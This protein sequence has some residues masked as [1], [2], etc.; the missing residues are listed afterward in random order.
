[1][2]GPRWTELVTSCWKLLIIDALLSVVSFRGL[3]GQE[4]IIQLAQIIL[5]TLSSI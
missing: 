4:K 2:N 5:V 1:M 3:K